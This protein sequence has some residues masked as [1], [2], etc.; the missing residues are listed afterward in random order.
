MREGWVL[1][2]ETNLCVCVCVQVKVRV[3]MLLS[4]ETQS[5]TIISASPQ[6]K[7]GVTWTLWP[8]R[9]VTT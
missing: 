8:E 7:L 4:N 5:T 9:L 1:D 6:K 2:V 3:M